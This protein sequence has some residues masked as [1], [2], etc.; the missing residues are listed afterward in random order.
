MKKINAKRIIMIS[1]LVVL[2]IIV[3]ATILFGTSITGSYKAAHMSFTEENGT[4]TEVKFGGPFNYNI[5]KLTSEIETAYDENGNVMQIVATYE[6]D[7][8]KS[9][10]FS[11]EPTISI[12]V[13]DTVEYIYQFIFDE[14]I[15]IKNGVLVD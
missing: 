8:S 5:V 14:T 4:I 6:G 15:I 2:F 1:V 3:S 12:E 9:F 13:S 10:I 7:V 11:D